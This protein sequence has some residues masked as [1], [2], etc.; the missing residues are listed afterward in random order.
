MYIYTLNTRKGIASVT[1]N[2]LLCMFCLLYNHSAKAVENMRDRYI[3]AL[4]MSE[5][6]T[7]VLL[8]H[9]VNDSPMSS[10]HSMEPGWWLPE[11]WQP[12]Q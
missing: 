7:P 12:I 2:L 8:L 6:D 11:L 3:I 9:V 5:Q 4:Y 1:N 10:L